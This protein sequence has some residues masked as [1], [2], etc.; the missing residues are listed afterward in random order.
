MWIYVSRYQYYPQVFLT[1]RQT[2]REGSCTNLTSDTEEYI[3]H[4]VSLQ[5]YL[6]VNIISQQLLETRKQ[7][8]LSQFS[9]LIY[10]GKCKDCNGLK[11][12]MRPNY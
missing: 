1:H 10:I 3:S 9:E 6:P 8:R 7:K 5:E 4:N 2:C 11:M 12:W